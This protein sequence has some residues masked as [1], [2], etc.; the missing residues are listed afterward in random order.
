MVK[1]CADRGYSEIPGIPGTLLRGELES[2]STVS[3]C[4][5]MLGYGDQVGEDH[6]D[7][8]A[9]GREGAEG[10][11]AVD[12]QVAGAEGKPEAEGDAGD[13]PQEQVAEH[14]SREQ[15]EGGEDGEE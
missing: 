15:T 3:S 10:F 7:V 11:E 5:D 8:G 1:R 2:Q 6:D 4:E 14:K 12:G 9:E 13:E